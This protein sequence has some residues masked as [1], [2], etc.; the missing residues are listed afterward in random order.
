MRIIPKNT[1][2]KM[3]FYK[4]VT[5]PDVIIGFVGLVLIAIALSSNLAFKALIAGGILT[6]FVPL[7]I[8][9]N[10]DR[11]YLV[12]AYFFKHIVSRKTYKKA[13]RDENLPNDIEGVIPYGT[14][15]A[16]SIVS[17]KDFRLAGIVEVHPVDFRMLDEFN[18]NEMIEGGFA[19]VLNSVAAGQEVDIIKVERPLILDNFI[20]DEMARIVTVADSMEKGELTKAEYEARVDII[21]DRMTTI[22]DLNSNEL[23]LC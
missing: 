18:Q 13:G 9:I 7:Y 14:I 22:D 16:D 23:I 21:Q 17:L 1:K 10:G 6:F 11:L 4:S 12:I 2:V 19:R 15:V 5:I 3:T 20:S 8:T